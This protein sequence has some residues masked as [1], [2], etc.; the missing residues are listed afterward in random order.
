MVFLEN[1]TPQPTNHI[2][3]RRVPVVFTSIPKNACT[4]WKKVIS[5]FEFP[6]S[7]YSPEE[8]HSK[9]SGPLNY[10]SREDAFQIW[11]QGSHSWVACLRDPFTRV[12]SAYLNK[13]FPFLSLPEKKLRAMG[14]PWTDVARTLIAESADQRGEP[15]EIHF[16]EAFLEHI[17]NLRDSG[18]A[19]NEHWELQSSILNAPFRNYS[20]FFRF[21]DL[22]MWR[23][24]PL[25]EFGIDK[26]MQSNE[27]FG[28]HGT[29][30]RQRLAAFQTRVAKD[31][32][33]SLYTPDYGLIESDLPWLSPT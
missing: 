19:L 23:R 25:S 30:A 9:V 1:L 26:S 18:H 20:G 24:P 7:T 5:D 32:V 8:L 12:L 28:K 6:G 14:L 16:F 27:S 29:Q 10:L 17:T 31:L 4:S 33:S 3:I 13:V 22:T 2:L 15:S 21:E 11:N